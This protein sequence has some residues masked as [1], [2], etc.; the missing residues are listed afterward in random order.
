MALSDAFGHSQLGGVGD[1][2]RALKS[3]YSQSTFCQTRHGTTCGR[4]VLLKRTMT[5]PGGTSC[6]SSSGNGE[7]DKMVTLLRGE[8]D[9]YSC[10]AGQLT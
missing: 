10:E 3:R 8:G 9:S 5:K 6:S 1:Y 7:T 4:T 2:L